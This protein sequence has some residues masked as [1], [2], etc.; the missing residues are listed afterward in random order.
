MNDLTNYG[1]RRM[2]VREVAD[3]LGVSGL[4]L[5]GKVALDFVK[6]ALKIPAEIFPAHGTALFDKGR[7]Q[8]DDHFIVYAP[9]VFNGGFFYPLDYIGR[10]PV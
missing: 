1:D 4:R 2:T 5:R 8:K 9:A 7:L 6:T 3:V 10:Q